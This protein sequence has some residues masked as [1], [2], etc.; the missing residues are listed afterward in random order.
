MVY[1]PH[2]YHPGSEPKR[3][4]EINPVLHAIEDLKGRAETLRGYL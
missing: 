1:N 3:M 4:L 2:L